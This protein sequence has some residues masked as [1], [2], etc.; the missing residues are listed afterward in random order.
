M[1]VVHTSMKTNQESVE[2]VTKS[3]LLED[4]MHSPL[5]RQKQSADDDILDSDM[6]DDF[7]NAQDSDDDELMGTPQN[8]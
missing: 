1:S 2:R 8:R 4:Q 3:Y 6:D 7:T 5:K